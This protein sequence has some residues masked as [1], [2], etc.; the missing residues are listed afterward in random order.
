MNINMTS[1][2][3]Y[4]NL[5]GLSTSQIIQKY[6]ELL[7]QR[8]KIINQLSVQLNESQE[9]YIEISDTINL[10]TNRYKELNDNKLK[11]DKALNQQ[12]TDKDLLFIKLTNLIAEN[13]KLKNIIQNGGKEVKPKE[14]IINNKDK[15][16]DV[17]KNKKENKSLYENLKPEI[18]KDNMNKNNNYL[19]KRNNNN[20]VNLDDINTKEENIK[21]ENKIEVKE[22]NKENEINKNNEEKKEIKEKIKN[23]VQKDEIMIKKEEKEEDIKKENNE[24]IKEMK[25]EEEKKN[26]K[27]E[28]KIEEISENKKEEIKIKENEIVEKVEEVHEE[29]DLDNNKNGEIKTDENTEED[30]KEENIV[31]EDLEIKNI[32]KSE[33][34]ITIINPDD[35]LNRKKRKKKHN[36]GSKKLL[37]EKITYEPVFK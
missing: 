3:K 21:F 27:N 28:E 8:E 2:M 5:E 32:S 4:I 15:N 24:E 36:K 13:D 26:D 14:I 31:D 16:I 10:L 11:C 23:D 22:R 34:K 17:K 18:T 37:S 7:Y 20:I 12:R 1:T 19:N 35:Y 6:E 25:K 33:K 30:K 29:K 9:K